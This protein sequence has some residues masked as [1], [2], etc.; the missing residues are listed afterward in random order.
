MTC[1]H[2]LFSYLKMRRNWEGHYCGERI[3]TLNK[4]AVSFPLYFNVS[5]QSKEQLQPKSNLTS[6]INCTTTIAPHSFS[7][8]YFENQ[9]KL[10]SHSQPHSFK[11][12][13]GLSLQRH[14]IG[15]LGTGL[16][17]GLMVPSLP[18]S[19]LGL[20]PYIPS[21]LQGTMTIGLGL[22]LQVQQFRGLTPAAL[23]IQRYS[24]ISTSA[25]LEELL[26]ENEK[27]VVYWGAASIWLVLLG[28]IVSAW[29]ATGVTLPVAT[30]S[31][32]LA[33]GST[34]W[35]KETVRVACNITN[36]A[37][38]LA[39]VGVTGYRLFTSRVDQAKSE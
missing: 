7:H 31:T 29:W 1:L 32:S 14:G 34:V 6:S 8:R 9:D 5:L 18:H 21:L 13:L 30:P 24:S 4:C 10:Q 22:L 38:M 28:E 36:V 33:S 17:V 26:G 20:T 35:W 3:P 27:R 25:S 15:L 11:T 16:L 12:P 37:G 19:R 2:I 23:A 39:M